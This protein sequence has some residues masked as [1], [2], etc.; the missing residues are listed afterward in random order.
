M[1]T[2]LG[3]SAST[4]DSAGHLVGAQAFI[5]VSVTDERVFGVF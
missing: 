4:S 5:R 1:K 3:L 2:G